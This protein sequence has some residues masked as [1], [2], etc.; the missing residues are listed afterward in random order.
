MSKIYDLIVLGAGPAGENVADVAHQS[1]LSCAV[2]ERHLV[3]GECSYYA[4][5]PSKALLRAGAA[6][7]AAQRVDGAKQ[8]VTAGVDVVGVL[9]RRDYMTSGGT[10]GGQVDWLKG[11]GIDL[12]R[13]IGR[14][15]GKKRVEVQALDGSTTVLEARHAV[16]VSTGTTTSTPPIPGLADVGYWTN[17]EA[18][19]T[20][21]IPDSLLI[22]GGGVVACE[23]A[24]AYVSFGCKVTMLVRG[25]KVLE[26]MED[27]AGE[28]VL[29]SLLELGVDVRFGVETT[30]AERQGE[31]V[32]L[33]TTLGSLSAQELLLATGRAPATVDIGLPSIG[34]PSGKYLQVDDTLL[35]SAATNEGDAWLY[36]VGDANGR[37]LLTHMGKYQGRAAGGV[38]A[39]RA[40]GVEVSTAAWGQFVATA[41]HAAVPQVV[42]TD[43]EV[44]AVGLTVE[45]ARKRGH[46]VRVVDYPLGS[47]SGAYLLSDGYT[48]QARM[49]VDEERQVLLGA[50]L[51]GQDVAELIHAATVAIVGEVKLER[52]WHVV[53]SFPTVSE[54]WLR[55][56][57]AYGRPGVKAT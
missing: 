25:K 17:R 14:L 9:R 13:G 34:L 11:A 50:T 40:L 39:A 47:V 5:V 52:L 10:D 44:A 7:R 22:L 45:E 27:F 3:G 46:R 15:Q 2:V 55:L 4:C 53:P 8:A 57:E 29:K 43:P 20:E 54:V 16:C 56:L 26:R 49:V 30:R 28:M 41:D 36:S 51:V 1:G 42:F 35:V 38:I 31:K 18:T 6:L 37:A 32:V 24:T 23:M 33:H 21:K 19:S 48:G 12:F